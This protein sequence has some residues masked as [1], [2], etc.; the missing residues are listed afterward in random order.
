MEAVLR[1]LGLNRRLVIVVLVAALCG[2][3]FAVL[4]E[5]LREA[6]VLSE[7]AAEESAEDAEP[8]AREILSDSKQGKV[9]RELPDEYLGKTLSEIKAIAKNG[10]GTE[11]TKAR[12]GKKILTRAKFGKHYK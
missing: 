12:K 2:V 9:G 11:K 7:E 8:T 5:T 3:G 10:S 4:N 1:P 6:A